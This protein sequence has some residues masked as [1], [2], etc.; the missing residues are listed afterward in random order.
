MLIYSMTHAKINDTII[1]WLGISPKTSDVNN[2]NIIV[3]IPNQI[4]RT[5]KYD[6]KYS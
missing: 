4:G 3:A 1:L 6:P 2:P 5:L